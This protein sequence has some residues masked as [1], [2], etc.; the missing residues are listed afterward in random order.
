MSVKHA[1]REQYR[2]IVDRAAKQADAFRTPPEG[3]LRTVREALGMSGAELARRRGVSRAGIAINE[4]AELTGGVTLRFM[5]TSAEAM[6]CRFVYAI[7]PTTKNV[8]DMI[9]AQAHKKAEAIV[10]AERRRMAS[11]G[12][13]LPDQEIAKDVARIARDLVRKM[14]RDFWEDR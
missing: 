11:E 14:P 4:A 5:Q 10:N 9:A 6:G 1:K 2:S 3:W 8:K 12:Q 7:V 13:P